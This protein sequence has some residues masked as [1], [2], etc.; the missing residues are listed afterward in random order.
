M[1]DHE[2]AHGGGERQRDRRVAGPNRSASRAATTRPRRPPSTPTTR[3]SPR[4]PDCAT[5]GIADGRRADGEVDRE[6]GRER[7][8]A[9]TDAGGHALAAAESVPDRVAVADRPTPCRR[10]GRRPG[11]RRCADG[12]RRRALADVADQDAG[13]G[14]G[15]EHVGRVE[16]AGVPVRSTAGR[17]CL[18]RRGGRR[19]RQSGRCR[20]DSRRAAAASELRVRTAAPLGGV[21]RPGLRPVHGAGGR[22]RTEVEFPPCC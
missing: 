18:R 21:A 9:L 3:P 2:A 22:Q 17:R 16:A 5:T 13:A 4:T 1:G 10:C 20:A 14:R 8:E 6:V 15:A 12:A 7:D 19:G 11:R